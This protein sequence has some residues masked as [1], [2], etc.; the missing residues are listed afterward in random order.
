MRTKVFALYN[1]K[2]GVS[3]TT[4]TFN[5]AAYLSEKKNL[6]ILII[7]ADSQANIT[8]LFFASDPSFW[9][10]SHRKTSERR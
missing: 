8:E 10:S 3:K 1:N 2:G 6:K 4:T 9:D 7:D 5:L